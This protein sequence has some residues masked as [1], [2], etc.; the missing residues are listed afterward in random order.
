V[1]ILVAY[2][3]ATI[4]AVYFLFFKGDAKVPVWQVAIPV[5]GG[6]F[7]CYTIYRNVFVGQEGTYARLPYIEGVYLI[8]GLVVVSVAPGLAGR[9][10]NG[11]AAGAMP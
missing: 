6:A 1:L 5:L 10:R 8:I 2:V 9:V 11:L 7:V 3:L 4:G